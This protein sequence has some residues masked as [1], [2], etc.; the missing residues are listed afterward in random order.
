MNMNKDHKFV[1]KETKR[2]NCRPYEKPPEGGTRKARTQLPH[3]NDVLGH[4]EFSRHTVD[5]RTTTTTHEEAD[6]PNRKRKQRNAKRD[7]PVRDSIGTD[8]VNTWHSRTQRHKLTY[9]NLVDLPD[10]ELFAALEDLCTMQ[11]QHLQQQKSPVEVIQI[12]SLLLEHSY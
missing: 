10:A 3:R 5:L 1:I 9:F 12:E 8:V 2:R 7:S 6:M 11:H 4:S